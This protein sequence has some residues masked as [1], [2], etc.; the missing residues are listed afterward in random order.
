MLMSNQQPAAGGFVPD[1]TLPAGVAAFVTTRCGGVSVPPYDSNNLGTHVGDD[2][3]SVAENRRRL[4]SAVAGL[5]EIQ[6][7]DQVHGAD[8]IEA[9]GDGQVHTA[10]AQ[11]SGRPGLG[12]AVLTADCLPV[13]FCNQQGTRVAAAHA[14]WRGLA[15]GVLLNT[16]A[17]FDD[18]AD[19]RAYLGPAIGPAAFEVGP[20]VRRAFAG[21]PDECFRKGK[22]DRLLADLYGLAR[23]QLGNAGVSQIC[24]GDF[25]T[26]TERQR[27]YSYRRDRLTGRQAS[28]IWLV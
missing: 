5:D 2:A 15:A 3:L 17:V 1:W 25:C 6:W 24:G 19:V 27:F 9:V 7:L 14:G 21:A 28:L 20:E 23:W 8:V 22:G 4:V 13:L 12:C 11:F 10:D 16:L 18:P 26:Y